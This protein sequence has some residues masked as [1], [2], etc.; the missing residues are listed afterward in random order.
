MRPGR[1]WDNALYDEHHVL[2]K[3]V[4]KHGALMKTTACLVWMK[5]D[6]QDMSKT[7]GLPGVT[8]THSPCP[9]CHCCK[10]DMLLLSEALSGTTLP[11]PAAESDEYEIEC[12]RNEINVVINTELIRNRILH[13]GALQYLKGSK[14]YGRTITRPV[15]EHGLLA[16]DVLV[17]SSSLHDV[18]QFDTVNLP[19]KV[20]FWRHR[21]DAAGHHVGLAVHRNP[22]FSRDLGTAPC[23]TL[24]CDT[25]HSLFFGPISRWTSATLHR[26]IVSNPWHLQGSQ[27]VVLHLACR[28][29]RGPLETWSCGAKIPHGDR[30][31]DLLPS[32]LGELSEIEPHPGSLL[33]VKAY[34]AWILMQFTV[35]II[36]SIGQGIAHYNELLE[37]GKA[38][39]KAMNIMTTQPFRMEPAAQQEIVE[40]MHTHIALSEM[41]GIAF[42]PKHHFVVHMMD[43]SG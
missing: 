4:A 41:A 14:R 22:V 13:G 23:I 36:Q 8:S 27:D 26:L 1:T 32:M 12:Q 6:L 31:R 43:R 10:D 21:Y 39:L 7:H 19:V 2:G 17:P 5:N 9:F 40:C 11:W 38:M 24:A 28:R 34:E 30:V 42:V 29:L 25:L 20:T 37:A 33:K 15:V 18:G 3:M 16:G 35:H